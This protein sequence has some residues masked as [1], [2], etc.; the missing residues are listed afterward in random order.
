MDYSTP[1][2]IRNE[3]RNTQ[4]Q[5]AW[6]AGEVVDNKKLLVEAHQ[7]LERLWV[8]FL[9]ERHY[10]RHLIEEHIIPLQKTV[11]TNT[12]KDLSCQCRVVRDF[13]STTI[14]TFSP[15]ESGL[16]CSASQPSLKSLTPKS[17]CDSLWEQLQSIDREAVLSSSIQEGGSSNE[18]EAS[19]EEAG[20]E[21]WEDC[22]SGGSGGGG[23]GGEDDPDA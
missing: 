11:H 7:D 9:M 18:A 15:K 10:I 4:K 17:S 12:P 20:S 8:Q 5:T 2:V 16:K 6:L 14:N 21:A 22:C 13:P 3:F 19:D 23:S 1:F